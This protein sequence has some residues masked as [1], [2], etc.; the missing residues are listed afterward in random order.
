MCYLATGYRSSRRTQWNVKCRIPERAARVRR[1]KW[2]SGE[3]FRSVPIRNQTES[4]LCMYKQPVKDKEP[5]PAP[6]VLMEGHKRLP[7]LLQEE[8]KSCTR[9]QGQVCLHN[10]YS[11]IQKVP[12][13]YQAAHPQITSGQFCWGMQPT[14][15]DA[16][17]HD[18]DHEAILT[19]PISSHLWLS[20]NEPQGMPTVWKIETLRLRLKTL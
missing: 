17:G 15:L 9:S 13:M 2:M 5:Q 10:G 12:C 16:E 20:L 14:S 11:A 8:L 6:D 3:T 7:C 4:R 18:V 1:Q 19:W